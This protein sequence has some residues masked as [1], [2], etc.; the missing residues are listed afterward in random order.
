M[1]EFIMLLEES[2]Q[3]LYSYEGHW[4]IYRESVHIHVTMM[5]DFSHNLHHSN[6][7]FVKLCLISQL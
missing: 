6:R 4:P 1:S 5:H 3:V 2:N 7:V